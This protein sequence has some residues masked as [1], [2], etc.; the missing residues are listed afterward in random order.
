L[1]AAGVKVGE[2]DRRPSSKR[3]DTVLEQG[4]GKGR[5]VE[6]GSSVALVVAAPLPRVPGVVGEAEASAVRN[7]KNAGFAV[8]RTTQTD[9]T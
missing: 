6:P 9:M 1:R 5:E 8:K 4:V 7:L 3:K 2:V